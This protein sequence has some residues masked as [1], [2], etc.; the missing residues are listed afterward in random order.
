MKSKLN[1]ISEQQA[2]EYEQLG[3]QW[4][5]RD[6]ADY[7]PQTHEV[8]CEINIKSEVSYYPVESNLSTELDSAAKESGTTPESLLNKWLAEKLHDR[9]INK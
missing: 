6:L 7:W 9:S 2:K 8:E 4:A 1:K 3:E 5:S